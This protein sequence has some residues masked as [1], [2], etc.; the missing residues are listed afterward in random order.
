MKIFAPL[1]ADHPMVT[2]PMICPIC[3]RPFI[4]GDVVVL[5]PNEPR[6]AD[7]IRKRDAGGAFTTTATPAHHHCVVG[8]S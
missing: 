6:D 8:E 3:E 7:N 2:Q 5:L 4:T 1:T